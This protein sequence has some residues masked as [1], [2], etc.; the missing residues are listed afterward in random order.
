M[1]TSPSRLRAHLSQVLID[2]AM[3]YV[4]TAISRPLA[5]PGP[6]AVRRT[7]SWEPRQ[8]VG[9]MRAVPTASPTSDGPVVV[10]PSFGLSRGYFSMS[11]TASIAACAH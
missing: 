9:P 10:Q 6:K 4:K 8:G 3:I 11:L 2:R 7:S 5:A 1:V